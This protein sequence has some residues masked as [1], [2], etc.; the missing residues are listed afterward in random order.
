MEV[1]RYVYQSP[2][3]SPV[4]FGRPDPSMQKDSE[5]TELTQESSQSLQNAQ[6]YRIKLQKGV[7]PPLNKTLNSQGLFD[8]YA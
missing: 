3:N 1:K 6:T 8:T 2:Y 4:Q 5:Q 7:E